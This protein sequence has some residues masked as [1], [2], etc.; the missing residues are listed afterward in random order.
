EV[1]AA[2]FNQEGTRILSASLDKTAKLWDAASGTLIGSFVHA[3]PVTYAIFSPDGAQILTTSAD[4][5]AKLWDAA[6]G[7]LIASFDHQDTVRWA[8]FSPDGGWILTA[9]W[10]KTAKL[11]DAA[12]PKKLALHV[13][14]LSETAGRKSTSGSFEGSRALEPE[15]LATFASNLEFSKDGSL[16]AVDEERRSQLKKQLMS[17]AADTRPNARFQAWFLKNGAAQTVFPAGT[18]RISEWVDNALLTNPTV[19]EE[20][21]RAASVLLPENPLLH[22]CLAGFE[23]DFRR[24]D[25]LR[26]FGVA[27]LPN[28]NAVCTRACEMLMAQHSFKLALAAI[29]KALATGTIDRIAQQQLRLKV[30]DSLRQ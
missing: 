15:A 21:L 6:S 17:L 30:L 1:N 23:K 7:K 13:Q 16:V 8:A 20:W 22:I 18:V 2:V 27:K 14:G 29:D 5:T 9:S 10:D 19:N 12:T 26:S 25:F 24:A 3:A 28:D 11:W 4:N